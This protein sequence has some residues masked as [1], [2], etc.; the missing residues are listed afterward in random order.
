MLV[1]AVHDLLGLQPLAPEEIPRDSNNRADRP[2]RHSYSPSVLARSARPLS[3]PRGRNTIP[4][5]FS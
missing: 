2:V 1:G 4:P 5:S 3:M